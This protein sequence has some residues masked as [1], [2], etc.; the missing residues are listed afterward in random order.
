MDVSSPER[1]EAHFDGYC[2]KTEECR[3]KSAKEAPRQ[4]KQAV[5]AALRQYQATQRPSDWK[6]VV[7]AVTAQQVFSKEAHGDY[8]LVGN[9]VY[10]VQGRQYEGRGWHTGRTKVRALRFNRAQNRWNRNVD[11]FV[12]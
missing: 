6:A 12:V 9:C 11:R 1:V 4:A 2:V 3:A 10:V 7:E 8:F 5:R